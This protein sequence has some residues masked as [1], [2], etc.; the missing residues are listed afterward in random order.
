MEILSKKEV[1]K[2]IECYETILNIGIHSWPLMY[3]LMN[4]QTN[5]KEVREIIEHT[6]ELFRELIG[7]NN[8]FFEEILHNSLY[9]WKNLEKDT[10]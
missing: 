7:V 2:F 6:N 1:S 5:N 10:K 9:E 8:E 3:G 4:V